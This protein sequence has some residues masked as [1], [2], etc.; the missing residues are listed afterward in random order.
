M[1]TKDITRFIRDD[2]FY[3]ATLAEHSATLVIA[4]MTLLHI[5]MAATWNFHRV[6]I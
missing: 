1:R 6:C 3:L 4:K 5:K 2:R